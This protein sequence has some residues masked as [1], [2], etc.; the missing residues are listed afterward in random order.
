[1]NKTLFL[2]SLTITLIAPCAYGMHHPTSPNAIPSPE[3][4][5]Q[6]HAHEIAES[7]RKLEKTRGEKHHVDAASRDDDSD[8]NQLKAENERI[9]SCLQRLRAQA[10]EIIAQRDAR[11]AQSPTTPDQS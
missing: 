10:D 4:T 6:F 5:L 7:I 11:M 9:D 3:Q 1:M 8:I 2:N